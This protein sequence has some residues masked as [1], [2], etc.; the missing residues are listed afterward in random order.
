MVRVPDDTMVLFA[1]AVSEGPA[2]SDNRTSAVR[3]ALGQQDGQNGKTL[4]IFPCI[5]AQIAEQ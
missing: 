3:G 4:S 2:E 5:V 1:A